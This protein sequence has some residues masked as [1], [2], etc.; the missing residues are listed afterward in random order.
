MSMRKHNPNECQQLD[1]EIRPMA[2]LRKR[3]PRAIQVY[4]VERP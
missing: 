2:L 4:I 1:Y 3:V